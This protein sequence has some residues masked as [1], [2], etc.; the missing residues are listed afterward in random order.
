MPNEQTIQALADHAIQ[1]HNR[2]IDLFTTFLQES[3]VLVLVFGILDTYAQGKL[4]WTVGKV[5]AVLG[6]SLF[7]AAFTFR[8]LCCRVV[9]V[10]IR[11][12]LTI[13]EHF[14]GSAK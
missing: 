10:I 14:A 3:S 11:Y 9:R 4:T 8:W 5:V 7:V 12:A 6:I 1:R 2:S 13:Q